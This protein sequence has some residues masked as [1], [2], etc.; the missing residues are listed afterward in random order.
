MLL[1]LAA[2]PTLASIKWTQVA[3]FVVGVI[4]LA[5]LLYVVALGLDLP[6]EPVSPEITAV[7]GSAEALARP[8]LTRYALHVEVAGILLLA[9]TVGAVL[10]AQRTEH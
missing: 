2:L 4:V 5:Q 6:M 7:N 1:N 10:F 3:G 8:L 9:A